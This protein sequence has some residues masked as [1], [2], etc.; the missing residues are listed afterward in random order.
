M[1]RNQWSQRYVFCLSIQQA[2]DVDADH[3]SSRMVT[4]L[5][6]P[7]QSN[8]SSHANG[9]SLRFIPSG[10]P[11]DALHI[12]RYLGAGIYAVACKALLGCL[13]EEMLF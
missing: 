11:S 8:V 10:P 2:S 7:V 1:V 12:Y 9:L 6:I 4:G 5:R 3:H 13:Q